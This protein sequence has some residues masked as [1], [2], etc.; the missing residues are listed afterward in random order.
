MANTEAV[1]SAVQVL[2]AK[3]EYEGETYSLSL[4]VASYNGSFYHEQMSAPIYFCDMI[5]FR[6]EIGVTRGNVC[7]TGGNIIGM[8]VDKVTAQ[9]P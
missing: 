7:V 5:N 3:A 2:Q 8:A 4:R 6:I 1:S 9:V